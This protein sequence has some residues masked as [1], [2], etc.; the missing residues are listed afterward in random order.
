[1]HERLEQLRGQHQSELALAAGRE[2]WAVRQAGDRIVASRRD[3][4]FALY[5][6]PVLDEL[7]HAV[8]EQAAG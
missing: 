4:A 8:R 6:D 7:H 3:W 1:M 2:A 5:P